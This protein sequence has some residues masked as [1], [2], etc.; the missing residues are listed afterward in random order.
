VSSGHASRR[1]VRAV[2]VT[3]SSKLATTTNIQ[4]ALAARPAEAFLLGVDDERG[5][6]SLPTTPLTSPQTLAA[7]LR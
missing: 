7:S 5:D 6:S 2:V 4:H 1:A 3:S